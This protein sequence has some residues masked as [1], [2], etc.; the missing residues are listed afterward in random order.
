MF[1]IRRLCVLFQGADLLQMTQSQLLCLWRATE[2]SEDVTLVASRAAQCAQS[3]ISLIDNLKFVWPGKPAALP[4]F[5]RPHC[6]IGVGSILEL[7]AGG[8]EGWSL[9]S[10]SLL[11]YDPIPPGRPMGV[12]RGGTSP[13]ANIQVS[14]RRGCIAR[15]QVKIKKPFPSKK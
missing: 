15:H 1:L 11:L 2:T 10:F 7:H 14:P 5:V 8:H 3:I 9:L 13:P 12:V 4:V 6:R